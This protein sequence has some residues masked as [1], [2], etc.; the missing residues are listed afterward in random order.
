MPFNISDLRQRGI[1]TGRSQR[2]IES[3]RFDEVIYLTAEG[4]AEAQTKLDLNTAEVLETLGKTEVDNLPR[5]VTR[6]IQPDGTI[7]TETET[8]TRSLLELGFTPNRYQ[9]SETTIEVEL[10][11][12]IT[13]EEQEDTEEEGSRYGIYGGTYEVTEER[14][15]DRSVEANAKVTTTIEPVPLPIDAT[16]GETWERTDEDNEPE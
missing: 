11:I 2:E 4:I 5:T 14:K 7:E 1:P 6:N 13:E 16:L 9:F 3:I 15:Y 8:A 10:D 12:K